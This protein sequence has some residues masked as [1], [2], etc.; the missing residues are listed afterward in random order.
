MRGGTLNRRQLRRL[1]KRPDVRAPCLC[2]EPSEVSSQKLE[3]LLGRIEEFFHGQAAPTTDLFR[4]SNQHVLV[5]VEE[6]C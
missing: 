6:S 5:V 2:P 3:S 1:L 4:D